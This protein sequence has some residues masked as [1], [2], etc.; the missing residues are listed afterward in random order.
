PA[1]GLRLPA[2]AGATAVLESGQR[3]IAAGAP[4]ESES[5]ARI[6]ATDPDIRMP[7][8]GPRL[9]AAQ[10]DAIKRWIDEGG[11]WKE[12]WAFRP[13]ARPAVPAVTDGG[14]PAHPIDAF[15]RDGLARRGLPAPPPADKRTLLRRATYGVTGLPPTEREMRDFLCDESPQAWERVVDRLL[16]SPRY[17][18]HWARHWLDLVRYADTNSFERDGDKPHAWRYRD[19]VIRSFNDDKPYD[20]FVTE[21][22]A[23]DELPEPTNDALIATGYYRLGVWDDEPADREQFRYDWLDDIVATTGQVFLGLTVNCARCHDHKIDPIPQRD[24]YS[25]LSFFDN[26][27]PMG[28]RNMNLAAIERSIFATAADREAYERKVADLQ[29]R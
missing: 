14:R 8:E 7:P 12:H 9:T 29:H 21:Q 10:I 16:A 1:P 26:I 18:E 28:D 22:I 3:A 5:L 20:R 27:T 15:I 19:Y 23:G 13:P 17:G 2:Q 24:Y 25:L 11:T 6:P 4:A